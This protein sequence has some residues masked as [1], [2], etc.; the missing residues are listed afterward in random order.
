M[1]PTMVALWRHILRFDPA[2]PD[3]FARDR[4]VMSNGHV[5]ILQYI[6]LHLSGYKVWTM[7]QLKG[8]VHPTAMNFTNMAKTHPEIEF[9][10]IDIS[11]GPL[12]QGIGNAVGMAM[13]N[14]NLRS[15]YNRDGFEVVQGTVYCTVGDACLQEGVAMEGKSTI[16]YKP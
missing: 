11:T 13:A 14:M 4:F 10:G 15:T 6:V 16:S 3:W 1:A 5:A 7:E 9:D 8:Y 2:L 12:G